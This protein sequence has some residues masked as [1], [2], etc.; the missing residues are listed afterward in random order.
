[1]SEKTKAEKKVTMR[2]KLMGE[3]ASILMEQ[4]GMEELP[5]TKEGLLFEVDG[6]QVVLKF[7]Q[8]KKVVTNADIVEIL[9]PSMSHEGEDFDEEPVEIEMSEDVDETELAELDEVV[10]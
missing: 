8:K 9:V 10:G 2:E 5:R 4:Y 3:V 1:M 7:I 6:E